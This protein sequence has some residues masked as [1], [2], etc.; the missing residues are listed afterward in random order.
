MCTEYN[1]ALWWN[2]VV[3][4]FLAFASKLIFDQ[5]TEA[6]ASF[7]YICNLEKTHMSCREIG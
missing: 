5:Q 2:I 4:K 6:S 7:A 3:Y 1:I